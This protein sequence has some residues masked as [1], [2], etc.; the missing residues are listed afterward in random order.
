M[1]SN[2]LEQIPIRIDNWQIIRL[3]SRNPYRRNPGRG[4]VAGH[5]D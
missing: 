4:T 1:L 3:A 2:I 5:D